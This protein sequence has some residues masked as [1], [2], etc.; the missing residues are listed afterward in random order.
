MGNPVYH[1]QI[2]NVFPSGVSRYGQQ[3]GQ[4]ERSGGLRTGRVEDRGGLRTGR[5]ENWEG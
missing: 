2:T 4:G 1:V 5:V 3:L